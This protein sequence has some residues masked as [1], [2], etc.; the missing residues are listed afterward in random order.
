MT[1]TLAGGKKQQPRNKERKNAV[2]EKQN[3]QI[4]V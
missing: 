4:I 3:P 1:L 2:P